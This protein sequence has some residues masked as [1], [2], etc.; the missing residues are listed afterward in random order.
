MDIAELGFSVDTAPVKRASGDLTKMAA[1]ARGAA[2]DASKVDK[3]MAGVAAGTASA[4]KA[5]GSSSMGFRNLGMQL[6]QVAQ[7]GAVTGNYMQALAIQLP[8][9]LIGFGALGIAAGIAAGALAPLIV[10]LTGA[11]DAA[12]EL[13]DMFDDLEKSMKAYS[14][15]AEL[16]RKSTGDLREE[17]GNVTPEFRRMLDVM[18]EIDLQRTQLQIDKIN[19]ALADHI[20]IREQGATLQDLSRFFNLRIEGGIG[21]GAAAAGRE[22]RESVATA[23]ELSAAFNDARR[24]LIESEGSLKEQA[25]AMQRLFDATVA[26]ADADGKRTEEEIALIESMGQT[27][28]K[29]QQQQAEQDKT[30][31]IVEALVSNYDVAKTLVSEISGLT[32]GWLAKTK[33]LAGAAWDYV[34]ALGAARNARLEES[35]VS[36]LETRRMIADEDAAMSMDLTPARVPT[37]PFDKPKAKGGGGMS[38]AQKLHNELLQEAERLFDAT[39]TAAESYGLE[40]QGLQT[41]LDGDYITQDTFNR[42]VKIADETFRDAVDSAAEYSAGI[43]SLREMLES[44]AISQETFNAALEQAKNKMDALK[45]AGD[46]MKQTIGD[47]FIDAITG[48]QSFEDAMHSL[49]KAIARAAL[50][51]A[52]FGDG[53]FGNLWG[54]GGGLFDILGFHTGTNYAPGGTALVGERGPELVNLPKGSQVIPAQKTARMMDQEIK[55]NVSTTVQNH[56]YF[57]A[58][59]VRAKILNTPAGERDI[60]RIVS[61]NQ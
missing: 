25:A 4:G 1:A 39:R 3:S 21:R 11:G 47:A 32:D 27:L 17:F 7:Q 29:M 60:V 59:T 35:T 19:K 43:G 6:N 24:E 48:A 55:P 33:T 41:L 14:E 58:D 20:S 2:S 61:E 26:L 22:L 40:L 10:G 37:N 16:A 15:S 31:N 56:I 45:E 9:M 46:F 50:Q 52:F 34:G 30:K 38:D 28:Q 44:G 36:A 53:P 8:D 5:A 23:K 51:A 54:G 13:G 42:G 49:A 18:A 57:D 12:E